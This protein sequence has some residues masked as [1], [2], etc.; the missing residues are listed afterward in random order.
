LQS[1]LPPFSTTHSHYYNTKPP[2]TTPTPITPACIP[3]PPNPKSQALVESAAPVDDA[4]GDEAVGDPLTLPLLAGP[5]TLAE[6]VEELGTTTVLVELMT[7]VERSVSVDVRAE[8]DENV[9]LKLKDGIGKLV[10]A[11]VIVEDDTLDDDVDD[12][13]CASTTWVARTFKSV[14]LSVVNFMI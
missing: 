10:V 1:T 8:S 7:D 11:E 6:E 9:E 12:D 5:V 3:N 13:T 14:R 4:A 2:K